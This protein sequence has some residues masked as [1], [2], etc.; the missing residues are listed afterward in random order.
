MNMAN[1]NDITL[2]LAGIFQS[3]QQVINLATNG[4][5]DDRLI[6]PLVSSVLKLDSTSCTDVYGSISNLR[7][8]L[9]LID[10]QLR[11]GASGKS[12]NLGRYVATLLNL[13]RHLS[14]SAEMKSV[15]ATRIVQVKRQAEHTTL[16]DET[17]IHSIAELYKDTISTLPIRIQVVGDQNQGI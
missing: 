15:I 1:F 12:A 16:M 14:R 5:A 4:Q 3:A 17:I 9:K 8:G 13:E 10:T 6:E 7:P 11:A 2:A